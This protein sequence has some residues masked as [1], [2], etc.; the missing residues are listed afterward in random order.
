MQYFAFDIFGSFVLFHWFGWMW[1]N[2]NDS[3]ISFQMAGSHRTWQRAVTSRACFCLGNAVPKVIFIRQEEATRQKPMTFE[4][5]N[6][7]IT[8]THKNSPALQ[9]VQTGSWQWW[10][11]Q[12]LSTANRRKYLFFVFYFQYRHLRKKADFEWQAFVVTGKYADNGK[13]WFIQSC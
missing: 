9:E 7:L 6:L 2:K 12:D 4:I 5:I 1:G 13:P 8:H 10:E 11:Q 3:N